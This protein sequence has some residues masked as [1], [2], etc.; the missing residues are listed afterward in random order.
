VQ[1]RA[2][3]TRSAKTRGTGAGKWDD[4]SAKF[5]VKKE[6]KSAS[7]RRQILPGSMKA[8]ALRQKKAKIQPI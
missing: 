5:K 7:T 1:L 3:I 2:L 8:Q 6:C 4:K